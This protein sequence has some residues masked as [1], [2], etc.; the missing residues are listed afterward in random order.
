M[1]TAEIEALEQEIILI[2]RQRLGLG[3]HGYIFGIQSFKDSGKFVTQAVANLSNLD[4]NGAEGPETVRIARSEHGWKES[5]IILKELVSTAEGEDWVGG[6]IAEALGDVH[7]SN[8]KQPS[9]EG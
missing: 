2:L 6:D 9:K 5:L 7:M 4:G 3:P 1:S 8:G